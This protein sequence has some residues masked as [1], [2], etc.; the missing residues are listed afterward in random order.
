MND[1]E[2]KFNQLL[3]IWSK[4]HDCVITFELLKSIVMS[5]DLDK[6][7]DKLLSKDLK[8]GYNDTFYSWLAN[9]IEENESYINMKKK[10]L[11][12][13]R[14]SRDEFYDGLEDFFL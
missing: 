12:D 11:N 5:I 6:V 10:Y 8:N 14:K 9:N 3:N 13:K 4:N 7:N 2:S 1:V